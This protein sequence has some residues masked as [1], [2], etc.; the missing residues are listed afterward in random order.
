MRN[1]KG[2]YEFPPGRA[3]LSPIK[4]KRDAMSSMELWLMFGS[5]IA[6]GIWIS[7]SRLARTVCLESVLHPLRRCRVCQETSEVTVLPKHH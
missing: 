4:R 1:G 2:G 3:S 6:L 7:F 5:L